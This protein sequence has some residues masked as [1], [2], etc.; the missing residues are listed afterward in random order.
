MSE[1]ICECGHSSGEHAQGGMGSGHVWTYCRK[2]KCSCREFKLSQPSPESSTQ[3]GTKTFEEWVIKTGRS[4]DSFHS[5]LALQQAYE[6]GQSNAPA[7][8]RWVKCSEM[9][10]NDPLK[11]VT[12]HCNSATGPKVVRSYI[13]FHTWKAVVYWWE[14]TYQIPPPPAVKQDEDEDEDEKVMN[15]AFDDG[16]RIGDIGMF[17]AG[18]KAAIK[19]SREKGKQ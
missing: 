14:W 6:A 19:H 8:G 1:Q 11:E 13:S 17:R 12:V 5:D 18:W 16:I 15:E 3:A 2:D 7:P 9:R 4:L 10:P